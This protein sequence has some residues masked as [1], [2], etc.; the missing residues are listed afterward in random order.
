MQESA[1]H[2]TSKSV[3]HETRANIPPFVS[4]LYF[5]IKLARRRA[6]RQFKVRL[7]HAFF[8]CVSV[9]PN[10]NRHFSPFASRFPLNSF[11]VITF[12]YNTPRPVLHTLKHD[13]TYLPFPT[14]LLAPTYALVQFLFTYHL[15]TPHCQCH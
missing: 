3:K 1:Q 7:V 13:Y 12:S 8:L 5:G 10:L 6:I 14:K 15:H 4:N 2:T 11:T 9:H